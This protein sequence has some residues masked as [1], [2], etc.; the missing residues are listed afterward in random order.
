MSSRMQR[1][2]TT[3]RTLAAVALSLLGIAPAW[4]GRGDLDPYYGE[5][6]RVSA[7]PEVMLA[8]SGDRLAI[9]EAATEAGFGA[10]GT[11]VRTPIPP[12]TT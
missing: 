6:G 2:C 4:A 7:I 8:L 5:G 3:E 10:A 11:L 12:T 1:S 9:A